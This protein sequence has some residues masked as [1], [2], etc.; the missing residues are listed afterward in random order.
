MS[1]E[2]SSSYLNILGGEQ[3]FADIIQEVMGGYES[4]E[5]IGS[6]SSSSEI[7]EYNS[8]SNEESDSDTPLVI[9]LDNYKGGGDEIEESPLIVNM[10]EAENEIKIVRKLLGGI[11][12]SE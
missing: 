8:S 10:D 4:N 9:D 3:F 6:S 7:D 12:N 2:R 1:E 11:I 5:Y